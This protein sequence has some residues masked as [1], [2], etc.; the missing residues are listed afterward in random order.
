[1]RSQR[2]AS[3][4]QPGVVRDSFVA[5][6]GSIPR[7]SHVKRGNRD[8]TPKL[9]RSTAIL[10][11]AK[12]AIHDAHGLNSSRHRIPLPAGSPPRPSPLQVALVQQTPPPLQHGPLDGARPD[13]VPRLLDTDMGIAH[14]PLGRDRL[15]APRG[16]EQRRPREHKREREGEERDDPRRQPPPV[17]AAVAVDVHAGLPH[18]EPHLDAPA[19]VGR[20]REALEPGA[21]R[22]PVAPLDAALHRE[23]PQ[24]R[25]RRAVPPAPLAQLRRAFFRD[26]PR[27]A[28]PRGARREDGP[29][30][31]LFQVARR[32]DRPPGLRRP[33]VAVEEV[34]ELNLNV[35]VGHRLG[36]PAAP[37]VVA[38]VV[39]ARAALRVRAD[40]LDKRPRGH[41]AQFVNVAGQEVWVAVEPAV[42]EVAA[43]FV[44]AKRVHRL[45]DVAVREP[46][47]KRV[48]GREGVGVVVELFVIRVQGRQVVVVVCELGRVFVKVAMG[49]RRRV[50]GHGRRC[51]RGARGC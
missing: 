3:Q 9:E 20:A 37:V 1:M 26:G 47:E 12:R 40:E 19:V 46:R 4:S 35:E 31:H 29:A 30:P 5:S 36:L 17:D 23:A 43:R 10:P 22:V 21:Q 51:F 14:P 15:P 34:R 16:Q 24:P 50:D 11:P 45:K 18:G 8:P 32:A 2:H 33:R 49:R 7:Y 38:V 48:K 28:E 25:G 44:A 39:A 27:A 41:L 13:G 6:L 42:E